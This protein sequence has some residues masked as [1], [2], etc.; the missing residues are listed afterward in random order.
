[1][2]ENQPDPLGRRGPSH[3]LICKSAQAPSS[4]FSSQQG[5]TLMFVDVGK[6]GSVC[7]V[8]KQVEL[9]HEELISDSMK[10]AATIVHS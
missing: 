8:L 5:A 9:Q 2:S 1:V 10:K 4:Q 7:P 6:C 3:L